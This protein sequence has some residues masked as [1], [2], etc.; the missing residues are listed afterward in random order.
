MKPLVSVIIVNWNGQKYLEKCLSSLYNQNYKNIEVVFVDN[1]SSDNSVEFVREKFPQTKIVENNDNLGFAEGN[2]IG[3][4]NATGEYI[5][6]LNNDAWV[7]KDTIEI[8]V[9]TFK[10]RENVGIVGPKIFNIDGTIQD[11]GRKIDLLGYPIGINLDKNTKLVEDLFYVSGCAM[12]LKRD[13]F[14]QVG[15][16]D[17]RF[18]MFME[19]VDLTWRIRLLGY[20]V[21]TNQDAIVFHYGGGSITGGVKKPNVYSTSIKRVYLRERNTLCMLIKNLGLFSLLKTIPIYFSLNILEILFFLILFKPKVCGIYLRSIWWNIVNLN[22]TLRRRKNIQ[23]TR[24]ISDNKIKRYFEN[25]IVKFS[26]IKR[27]GI[28]KFVK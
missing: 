10:E 26:L 22:D 11:I 28:P 9:N 1:N 17:D 27:I 12:M 18:F 14:I 4:Q 5:F 8:L 23:R 7:E 16:F 20:G 2:N 13:L 19:E 25:K 6:L 3:V 15:G 24:I 21:I